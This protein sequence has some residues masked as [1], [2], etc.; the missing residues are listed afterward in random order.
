MKI[1]IKNT[2]IFDPESSF[3]EQR[4]DVLIADGKIATIDDNMA[5][6]SDLVI[7]GNQLLLSSGW[8]DLKTDLCDPGN[9]H[10][11]TM[12]SGRDT[13]AAGGYTHVGVLPIA[14]VVTDHK[15][16]IDY[17]TNQNGTHPTDLHPIGAISKGRNGSELAELYDMFLSGARLFSD[18]LQPLNAA[19]MYRAL[20]YSKSFNGTI[21]SFPQ[22]PEM[23]GG[24]MVN[25]GHASLRTGLKANPVISE[26]LRI[27]RDLSLLRY[28]NGRLHISGISSAEGLDLIREA[29]QK[30]ANVTCD[31]NLMN[32]LF[33]EED[34]LN[35]NNRFKVSP[36]L[37]T[38]NDRLAL[39]AGLK[40]GTIDAIASDHRPS[41]QED[42][43]VVFDH[44]S[45]GTIQLQT[46]FSS[47]HGTS[48][49]ELT[50][51]LPAL[52]N[53]PRKILG[54]PTLP[55]EVGN[56]ADLTIV[57]LNESWRFTKETNKSL[58]FYS[59]FENDSF[60]AKVRGVINNG[61]F[62]LS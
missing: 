43:E 6:S 20:M 44:A 24:G 4:K 23:S 17:F 58:S 2:L 55:I 39:W 16:Q 42:K 26:V 19:L 37:R 9:E 11:E 36:C 25:E 60:T 33:T 3:H 52:T 46:V 35:F 50:T 47:L 12:A 59:P 8:A 51:V 30:N 22:D 53:G 38:E 45:I 56:R 31:V 21:V 57:D 48:N 14:T 32:L 61:I 13:A 1:L 40:D 18:D 34:V 41:D 10:K 28:T 15:G 54:I 5:E 7:E 49:F 62:V 27:Q 29:K